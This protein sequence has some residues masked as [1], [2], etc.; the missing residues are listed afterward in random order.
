VVARGRRG[1]CQYVRQDTRTRGWEGSSPPALY[2]GFKQK[3]TYSVF[4]KMRGSTTF[5]K[6]FV[7]IFPK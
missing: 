5:H 2:T 3:I 4:A 1:H 6:L 7:Q